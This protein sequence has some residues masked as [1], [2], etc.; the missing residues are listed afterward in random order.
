MNSRLVIVYPTSYPPYPM[1]LSQ[2]AGIVLLLSLPSPSETQGC[3]HPSPLYHPTPHQR[4]PTCQM[5]LHIP[6]LPERHLRLHCVHYYTYLHQLVL[7]LTLNQ[8]P[9]FDKRTLVSSQ[10]PQLLVVFQFLLLKFLHSLIMFRSILFILF[11]IPL[12]DA[13]CCTTF[14]LLFFSGI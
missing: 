11:F 6:Y 10:T 12:S 2:T 13:Y 14:R 9:E 8:D 1:I 3:Y 7:K 5:L 4:H